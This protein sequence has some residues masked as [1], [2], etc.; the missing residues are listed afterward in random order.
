MLVLGAAVALGSGVASLGLI[1]A[2]P[3]AGAEPVVVNC[4]PDNL[5]TAIN[6]A[7]S[8]ST[9]LV[10]GTCLGA[11]TITK[12]LT[13][14]GPAT[15]QG[16]T[17][18]RAPVLDVNGGVTATVSLLTIQHGFEFGGIRTEDGAGLTVNA[19]RISDNTSQLGGAG[20]LS[21]GRSVTL[22]GSRVVANRAVEPEIAGGGGGIFNAGGTLTLNASE[23]SLN[24]GPLDGGGIFNDFGTA[25][26]RFSSVSKNSG[27]DGGGIFNNKKGTMTLDRSRVSNNTAYQLGGG[28][29][30]EGTV[31]LLES[32]VLGNH[33]TNCAPLNSVPDCTVHPES[34]GRTLM[35]P[36]TGRG[37]L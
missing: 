11:F 35:R 34:V 7:S 20:I 15:L 5:Q 16:E 31:N 21:L 30:N 26:L 19:S 32:V 12:N 25:T 10:S 36:E 3:P 17:G 18:L 6:N 14:V 8:G 23:V 28:I 24:S 33:P 22:D 27:R 1:S 13:L 29:F 37:A 2:A 9:I 4:P